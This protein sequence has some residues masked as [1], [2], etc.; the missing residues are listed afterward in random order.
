[1]D[2]S[3]TPDRADLAAIRW[4]APDGTP[5]SCVEKLKILTDNLIELREI[6]QEAFEDALVIGCDEGQIREVLGTLIAE[7]RNPY[8]EGSR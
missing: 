3:Q 4:R 1:M 8:G 6:A 7:L 2:R 5:V